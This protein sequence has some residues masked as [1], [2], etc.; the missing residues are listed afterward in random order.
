MADFSG[1]KRC[2]LQLYPFSE[3]Q[4]E[5]FLDKLS[6]KTLQKKCYILK[7][8]EISDRLFFVV[9]G[10]LR[11]FT[12][13]QDHEMTVNFFTENNWVADLESLLIQQPSMNNIITLE[14]SELFFITLHDIH[15]L[16]DIYPSFRMLN[17]LLRD[18]TIPT[19][20]LAAITT[21]SPDERFKDLLL[22]KPDWINRFPQKYIASYL[23]ITPETL[24][25][26][27]ARVI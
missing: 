5:H 11:C 8:G 25:R 27:R 3:E 4:Q 22:H 9:S 21:K 18:I 12:N 16:T 1:I 2:L 17:A 6:Y 14:R 19:T 26:V 23:G 15:A 13:T 20:H 10:S 24:S 7:Q